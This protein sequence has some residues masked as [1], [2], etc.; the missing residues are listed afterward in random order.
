MTAIAF[1]SIALSR[2]NLIRGTSWGNEFWM[3]NFTK[4]TP[5]FWFLM[6]PRGYC[7]YRWSASAFVRNLKISLLVYSHLCTHCTQRMKT[8]YAPGI[9]LMGV[10]VTCYVCVNDWVSDWICEEAWDCLCPRNCSDIRQG[11]CVCACVCAGCFTV[12]PGLSLYLLLLS[13]D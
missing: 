1:E 2:T 11:Q 6:T 8:V 3:S 9:V 7:D 4:P 5:F 10:K 13:P 12:C